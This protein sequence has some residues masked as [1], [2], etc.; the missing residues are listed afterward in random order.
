MTQVV[1]DDIIPR[2][3]LT[4]SASQTVFNTNWTANVASDVNVY[5]RATGVTPDD[6]TQLVDPSLY[7][8]TFIG[9]SQTVRVTF[10]SGRSLNDIITIVRN[11]PADRMNLYINTN[12][13][14][15]MLNEDFGILTLVDQQAQMYDTVVNPGYN[16]SAT[17]ADKDKILPILGA[18]QVWAMNATNDAIIPFNVP[19]GGGVAPADATYILQIPN[20]SLVNAQALSLLSSGFSSVATLT[21]AIATRVFQGTSNQ[22]NITN[23]DGVSGDPVLSLSTTL[24]IPGTFNIQSTTAI[25]AIINDDTF[26]TAAATNIPTAL[27]VK[28]YVDSSGSGTV[29]TGLINEIAWY[30]TTGTAVSGLVTANNGVLTTDG[31]GAPTI[32]STLPIAVQQNIT[33][34]GSLAQDLN[35]NTHQITAVVDPTN[36]QDAATKNYVDSVISGFNPVESVNYASTTALTVSYNNGA[37]GV[38]ATLTNATTQAVFSLDG[39]NPTAGQRVLIKNQSSTFQ[40]GI[41]SVTDV[42]SVSTNWILTRTTDFDQPVDINN[43]GIVPVISGTANAGTGWL[44]TSTVTTIGTDPIVFIQFG[45][46]AGTIPVTSGGTGLTSVSQGSILYG[47]ASNVY[48]TL[49]KDTNATRYLSNTGTSNN[50]AWAQI[51]LANGVTGNLAVTN[52][53][54]GTSA[55]STTFWRGDGSWA[56]PAGTGVTSVSGTTNRVTSTGGTTPVI[57]ISA[58][59]VGQSS[60]TTLGTIATGVWQGTAIDLATYVTGNLAVAHLNSGTSASST[61]FWRGDG[62]WATPSGSAGGKLTSFQILTSGS[63]AT[64][65]KT[66]GT[67]SILVEVIGGGGGGGGAAA[68]SSSIVGVGGAGG[69]GGYARLWVASA[70]NTYTYTVGGGGAGGSAGNNDGTTGTTTTFSASSLQ[71]TGGVGGKGTAGAN[72]AAATTTLGGAGGVG[73]NGDFNAQGE[74]GG[75]SASILGNALPGL[76]GSSVYGGGAKPSVLSVANG[77][78]AGAYGSGGTGG[79]AGNSNQSGGAGST[80]LI[81]VWEF[82]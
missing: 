3:Q 40:N 75:V 48:S 64:Y 46:T 55:S 74:A 31:S 73:S 50:P 52:L 1:I 80:G 60:I 68:A 69:A 15:S 29:N 32:G 28:N 65:T 37:S 53:N 42:G 71:A 72:V 36:A 43:S 27:S 45:Q 5:A 30:A 70:S 58:S 9:G 59:Y 79:V 10:L 81:I 25:S 12:F 82:A 66:A 7:N 51:N 20:S 57:D 38:G 62:T 11:T 26:A 23:G 77:V 24:N 78:A 47:S 6:A 34:L 39:S 41:Y 17:I 49:A 14:P 54:S 2:T 22:I 19:T 56:T 21:G 63:A 44:E 8:V 33:K 18:N 4:A 13:V 35:M 76:G 67:L 16:V 61:T